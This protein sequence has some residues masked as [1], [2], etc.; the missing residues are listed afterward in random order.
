M[1]FQIPTLS[2]V[3]ASLLLCGLAVHA[4]AAGTIVLDTYG[5]DIDKLDGWPTPLFQGQDIA[6][7]FDLG[8]A[9][10]IQSILTSI[11]GVGGVTLGI[12]ARSAALPDGS[13]WLYSTHLVDPW[14]NTLLSPT[15]WTLGAG[16]YWL[17][18]VADAGFSGQWQSGTD[19]PNGHWAYSSGGSWTAMDSPFT[20]MPAARITVSAVPEP[21]SYALM[22][23]GGLLV[24]AA[25]RRKSNA[26]RG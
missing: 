11:D 16:S 19:T 5:P 22:L 13:G 24:A 4:S 7:A 1:Y 21:A 23:A 6:I 3:A 8:S 25:V 20:G 15:G 18:A 12:R 17:I 14:A 9:T 2:K 26:N 10:D